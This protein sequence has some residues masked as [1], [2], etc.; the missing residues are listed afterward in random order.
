MPNFDTLRPWNGQQ[1]RAFEELSFQLLKDQV[2][3]GTRAIRTGNP[4]GGVE[5]YAK[6]PDGTE[7]GWQAK[8]IKDIDA[9]LTAM[10]DSVERVSKE[11]PD[12]RKLIFVISSNLS[13]GKAGGQR[14]SQR[15]KYEDK[16]ATWQR[17]VPGASDINFELVQES[18]LLDELA[19]P[20]HEGRRWFWWEEVVL[21]HDWIEQRYKQQATA[22]G[23][24]YRP[25]LQVDI[26]IQEDLLALGFD[27][28]VVATFDRLRRRIIA[29]ASDL[30]L[31]AKDEAGAALVRAVEDTTSSLVSELNALQLQAG[32][33]PST[34]EQLKQHLS[35]C[36][37]AI[38]AA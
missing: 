18:D 6:M 4:D 34:L 8:Y 23:E 20:K 14:K 27:Q 1:S 38:N 29:A 25:D 28:T 10:T 21:G 22:A 7:C 37:R 30:R 9:L 12:L 16:V 17:T 36:R 33:L 13:T 32:D 3:P 19:K 26:P 15:E 24:K 2:P 31:F 11:R 35:T 5:W